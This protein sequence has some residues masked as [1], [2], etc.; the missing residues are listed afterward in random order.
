MNELDFFCHAFSALTDQPAPFGWQKRLYQRMLNLDLPSICDVP[1]GLGKTMVIPI[2]LI[3]LAKQADKDNRL[4]RRLIYI[5]NR[6]TVVDQATS[7]VEQIR[8]R[9]IAR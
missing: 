7:V 4:P 5:V 9:L 1:T 2:W 8:Q 6:R 3:A